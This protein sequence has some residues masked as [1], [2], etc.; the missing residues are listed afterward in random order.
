MESGY[1]IN[2]CACFG[3][4]QLRIACIWFVFKVMFVY[5]M[6]AVAGCGSAPACDSCFINCIFG[7]G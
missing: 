1:L 3:I 4:I 5:R 6:C 7:M 2:V